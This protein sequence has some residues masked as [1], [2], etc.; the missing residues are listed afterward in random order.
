MAKK[1]TIY[2][3]AK[4][5]NISPASVS[6]V[7]NNKPKVSRKTKKLVLDA[8]QELG[9]S[10]DY[11]GLALSTGK[12][13]AIA[14][15]LPHEDISNAFLQNQFYAEFI[16]EFQKEIQREDFDLIIKP[17]VNAKELVPWLKNRGIDCAIFI[18]NFP[19]RYY[20]YLKNTDIPAI[21]VDVF[22]DYA[23]EFINVRTD[24]ENGTY[25]GTKYLIENGHKV[26]GFLSADIEKSSLDKKRFEGYKRALE[27]FNLPIDRNNTYF[28]NATFNEGIN[29]SKEI[30][31]NKNITA[32][33]CAAD[34][35]AIGVMRGYFLY[36]KSIPEDLSIVGFDDIQTAQL[37]SP[38]LTTIN[39]DIKT[40][41][42]LT[43]NL[44]LKAIKNEKIDSLTNIIEPSLVVR[45][46]VNKI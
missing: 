30:R 35:L 39:Q 46:S 20:Q 42:K 12:T 28:V 24:D 22:E 18:G 43:A 44:A 2:D 38:S 37:V 45:K 25:I 19:K 33:V 1:I 10:R 7:L 14:L 16:G 40:K 6:Y 3:I 4:H 9:Y 41:A 21:L 17:L 15:F 26:I 11:K 5:L 32:L 13:R 27:E 36:G 8:I 31:K 34:T 23:N 29:I